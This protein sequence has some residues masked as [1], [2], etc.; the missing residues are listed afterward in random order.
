MLR[1]ITE[2]LEYNLG[3]LEEVWEETWPTIEVYFRNICLHPK[4]EISM[5][6]IDSYKQLSLKIFKLNSNN[7][8]NKVKNMVVSNKSYSKSHKNIINHTRV[9]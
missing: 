4:R 8:G 3:R 6:A 1:H 9:L 5:A 2:I 7:E